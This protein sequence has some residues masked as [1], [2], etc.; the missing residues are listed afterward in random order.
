MLVTRQ[1]VLRRFWYPVLPMSKLGDAPVPFRLLGQ[2]IVLWRTADG[3][4]AALTDR[5]PH[6]SATLERIHPDRP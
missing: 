3:S 6:R 1:N 4:P 2:D 5:C